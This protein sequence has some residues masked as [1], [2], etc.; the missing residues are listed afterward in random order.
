V[1]TSSA[2]GW[3]TIEE[4]AGLGFAVGHSCPPGDDLAVDEQFVVPQAKRAAPEVAAIFV[5]QASSR[6]GDL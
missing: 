2:R 5:G 3:A 4:A 1:G 6:R